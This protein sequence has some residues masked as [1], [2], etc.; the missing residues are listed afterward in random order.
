MKVWSQRNISKLATNEA[1]HVNFKWNLWWLNFH[2]PL[3]NR[4]PFI[5]IIHVREN[6]HDKI[7]AP[8]ETGPKEIY[9]E[10]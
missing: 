5:Y 6:I 4:T 2:D 3:K 10:V 1:C 9:L 8:F 7:N